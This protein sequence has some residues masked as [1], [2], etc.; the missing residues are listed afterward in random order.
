MS[1]QN[2]KY[3][4]VPQ[5]KV[6]IAER[7]TSGQ[8][9]GFVH[10]GDCDESTISV[11][12]TFLD[13]KENMSG[14]QSLVAHLLTSTD[15]STQLGLL[16][17]DGENLAR[18]FYGSTGTQAGGSVTGEAI[19]AYAG[20]M[21]FLKYPGVSAVTV[22]KGGTTLVAGTDYV[23]DAAEGSLSFLSGSTQVTGTSGVALTVDYTHGGYSS[24]VK[25]FSADTKDY[26]IRV[27]AK[28]KF[29]NTTTIVTL[30]R[31]NLNAA[32]TISLIGTGVNKLT[33]S[34][35]VLAAPE[36]EAGDADFSQYFTIV[37]K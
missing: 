5:G 27:V 16:S 2:T 37:Q 35:K 6:Y 14:L 31:V 20:Q 10:V 15:I 7:N 19:T 22:K 26:V 30:H 13:I 33:L 17:F 36:I 28:S 8:T 18:A 24:K 1:T 9:S 4:A 25:A 34:G 11:A 23:L 12:Q 21:T 32:A 29:D 3:F